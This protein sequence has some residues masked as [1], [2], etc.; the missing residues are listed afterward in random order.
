M[1]KADAATAIRA[2][3]RLSPLRPALDLAPTKPYAIAMRASP[4]WFLSIPAAVGL[5]VVACGEPPPA[6]DPSS[7]ELPL[8]VSTAK[9]APLDPPPA[10]TAKP[11]AA[12]TAT[13]AA[14]APPPS[15][16]GSGRPPVL[17]MD[18]EE[19][20]DSF[21]VSPGAKLELGSDEV[22]AIFKIP[23]NAF[24]SGVNVTFKIDKKGKSTG[25]P[26]GKIYRLTAVI[27]PAGEAVRVPTAGPP[28]EL[29]LP[30][31]AQKN[32]NLAI[33]DI[34]EGKITW[35]IVAPLKIDD[36]AGIAYFE[37]QDI[38]D[39]YLHITAKGVTT[40]PATK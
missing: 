12:P 19:I 22:K 24:S 15:N 29:Q 28:F 3:I 7:D 34:G 13:A 9:A 39:Y 23:E 1:L 35:R 26:V 17:K 30:A 40:P 16:Q 25:V 31:G 6:K 4:L 2:C 20:T 21:G 5:F 18:P 36:V 33:G 38:A 37:L 32:A 8:K 11:E 14:S 10:E 27:P